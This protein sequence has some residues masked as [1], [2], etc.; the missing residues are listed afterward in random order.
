MSQAHQ[1][2]SVA[3]R[4]GSPLPELAPA[5]VVEQLTVAYEHA[6]ALEDISFAVA[7]GERVA[8]VGPNGA[9]KSTLLKTIVGLIR[10]TTGTIRVAGHLHTQC[11]QVAYVPQRAE[12]D[13]SFPIS[14]WDVVM[15]GRIGH[16]GWFRSAGKRDRARVQHSLELVQ[17]TDLAHRQIGA[18]SGGQQQRVFVARALAQEA[19]VL[20]LDEPVTGLDVR[21]QEEVLRILDDIHCDGV[22]VLVATHDLQQAANRQHFEKVLLLNRRLLGAGEAQHVLTAEHLAAAYGGHLQRV[23]TEQG[24][25]L[26]P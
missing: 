18:L 5:L 11:N 3:L 24:V 13:W 6:Y 9:G 12:V 14:V 26:L 16:I 1:P 21:A 20:L 7:P 2:D 10:A 25:L 23:E 4:N 15:Q 17:M 19:H 22:T 8:V